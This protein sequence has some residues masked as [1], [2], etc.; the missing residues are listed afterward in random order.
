M[1]LKDKLKEIRKII[2]SAKRPIMMYDTDTDGVTSYLQIKKSFPKVVG[3]PFQR[4]I[5]RQKDLITKIPAECDLIII[6]DAAF[7]TEDF[8][9]L[10]KNYKIIWVDHHP[11]NN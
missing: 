8:L 11:T 10:I 5:G 1:N 3:F 6:F 4:E 7:L 9:E 2:N